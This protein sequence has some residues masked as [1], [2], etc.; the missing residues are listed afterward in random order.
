[1]SERV[2]IIGAFADEEEC[3]EAVNALKSAG[4]TPERVFS[5]VPCERLLEAVGRRRSPVRRFV[6]GGGIFGACSGYALTVGTSLYFPHYVGGKPMVS[7]T[8]FII[9]MFELMILCGAL[10]GLMGF[11]FLGRFPQLETV[12]GYLSNFSGDR[13]GL[14]INCDSNEQGKIEHLLREAGAEEIAR[15]SA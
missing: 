7:L 1:M 5:P 14:L 9:I 3:I 13:Y 8:P 6:L 4:F 12:G 15:E 11:F 10:S 2:G